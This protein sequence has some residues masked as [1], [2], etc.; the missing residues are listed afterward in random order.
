MMVRLVD[1][2]VLEPCTLWSV[3]VK[4]TSQET[5]VLVLTV[6][7]LLVVV[8]VAGEAAL[9]SVVEY[10]WPLTAVPPAAPHAPSV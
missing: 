5:L 4:V 8:S 1:S 2:Q 7:V 10:S 3:L 6:K 9:D